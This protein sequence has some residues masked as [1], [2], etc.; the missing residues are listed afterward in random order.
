MSDENVLT[1]EIAEQ[2]L[3]DIFSVEIGDFQAIEDAAA[4]SLRMH[5]GDLYL[6]ELTLLSDAGA[7]SLSNHKG[8]LYLDGLTE[9][10]DAQAASL[11][12]H[13]GDLSLNGL[14]DLSDAVAEGL[15]RHTGRLSLGG[16]AAL[17][18]KAAIALSN[19][20]PTVARFNLS[21]ASTLRIGG[22]SGEGIDTSPAAILHLAEYK[23]CLSVDVDRDSKKEDPDWTEALD[24]LDKR[25][26][27]R[28][29]LHL[30][31][32]M[33]TVLEQKDTRDE[34]LADVYEQFDWVFQQGTGKSAWET[35]DELKDLVIA[36]GMRK[37]WLAPIENEDGLY[38]QYFLWGDESDVL[39]R[40]S[41]LPD[42]VE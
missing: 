37:L 25:P 16:L 39:E 29:F 20:H 15:A 23:G 35:F 12:K 7:E 1:K 41:R 34:V 4:E 3:A 28:L 22:Y 6:A 18:E 17:T 8:C 11:G 2:F 13:Q 32:E 30:T 14:T 10:S 42:K 5:E 19:H 31:P 9:L 38:D 40:L 26:E 24:A 21:A 27:E 36:T 33:E